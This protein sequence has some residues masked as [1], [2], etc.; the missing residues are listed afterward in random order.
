[1]SDVDGKLEKLNAAMAGLEAQR[2]TLG[3]S[4]VEPALA[5]L[6][7]QSERLQKESGEAALSE[8]RKLVTVLFSDVSGFTALSEK[9][10]PEEVRRLI[11]ACFDRL[12]PIVQKY[13]GTVDKFIGDEVMALF[14]APVAHEDDPERALRAAL[15]MMDAI[16]EFNR[17]HNTMLGMH[18]GINTGR[19]VAG[20]VGAEGRRDYSVMGD[21]VNLAAR[22]EAAS[23]IGE[24]FV[25]PNTYRATSKLFN[26]ERVPPLTLK[27]KQAPVEVHRL[28]SAKP[29]RARIRGIE[30]LHAPLTGRDAELDQI[31]RRL[32]QLRQGSGCILSILGEAGLGKSRLISETR[33]I[34][35]GEARWAEGRALSYTTGRSYWLARD[36]VLSLL[37]VSND[38]APAIVAEALERELRHHFTDKAADFYPYLARM[39]GLPL[40]AAIE[41]RVKFLSGEALQ[42]RIFEAFG[43]YIR[44]Q[45][46]QSPIILVWEDLHWSDPSSL[47]L[48]E[49]IASLVRHLPLLLICAARVEESHPV[50]LLAQLTGQS[51]ANSLRLE[52]R[53][54]NPEE[55]GILM[56]A[57]LKIDDLPPQMREL[58][59]RRAE[60]NPF[61]IEEL[62]RSL[63]DIGAVVIE[64]AGPKLVREVEAIDVPETLQEVVAARIDRLRPEQKALLQKAS[65]VGRIFNRAVLL[66]IDSGNGERE[67]K[68]DRVLKELEQRQFIQSPRANQSETSQ[69]EED[70]FIFKHAITHDV[71]YQ[72]LLVATRK[73]L[74]AATGRALEAIFSH[75]LDELSP[76]LG[77]HF[78]RADINERAAAYLT[79]AAERAKD[80]F[81][82]EEAIA[83]Y[84]SAIHAVG[85]LLE[86]NDAPNNRQ[87]AVRLNEALGDLFTL[88]GKHD[89]ARTAFHQALGFGH[90]DSIGRARLHRKL[91]L[92]YSLQRNFQATEKE[93]GSADAELEK[94]ATGRDQPWWEEKLQIQLE[95]MHLLYWRGQVSEMQQLAEQYRSAIESNGSATQQTKLLKMLALSQLLQSR[96][97]PPSHCVEVAGRAVEA[98]ETIPDLFEKCYVRFTLGLIQTFKDEL[99]EAIKSLSEALELAERIGERVLEC[100]CLTYLALANRRSGDVETTRAF[101]ERTVTLAGKLGMVEYL[102][103]AQ[104]NLAWVAWK[105]NR[106]DE[107]KSLGHEALGLWHGM[108]DPYSMDW[109]ALWPLI[110]TAIT[111]EQTADAIDLAQGLFRDGQHLIEQEVMSAT[112]RAIESWGHGDRTGSESQLRS[113]LQIA[114]HFR[115]L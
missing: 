2:A 24:I 68:L 60:G 74:H 51:P 23:D 32:S 3:D 87:S 18:I 8:E 67:Q 75:R 59:V 46:T 4:V 88:T 45:A 76:V 21:A 44:I 108:D 89:E 78:Q 103:M 81:A 37:Q 20:T 28:V 86:T 77:H 94:V 111:R 47:E 96:F 99:P 104:A 52:L 66:E 109:I 106:L 53:P 85:R 29:Q 58:I 14:G 1:M 22:L 79:R 10:D 36:L 112:K 95:R 107:C 69:L 6:R 33:A 43:E 70:E 71:A 27:G 62:L 64:P 38:A 12:V 98:S 105:E 41:E 42:A 113:A 13:E 19:V 102:A 57:L 16:T 40:E 9:L 90:L 91:G 97:L 80:A 31:R 54:L 26:F 63:L 55:S 92:A 56:H 65:V 82:N 49:Q 17:V 25:G 34:A 35:Q 50:K 61:Y 11:N 73:E 115:Y 15:D 30:G 114:E 5:A 101:A 100:R 93:F 72:S 39:L 84:R 110:A 7:A 48:L 83:Y